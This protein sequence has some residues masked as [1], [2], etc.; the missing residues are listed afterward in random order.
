[1]ALYIWNYSSSAYE[2][3][4]NTGDNSS[5]STLTESITSNIID[6][7]GGDSNNTITLFAVTNDKANGNSGRPGRSNEGY[8]DIATDY[9]SVVITTP[10]IPIAD[11]RFDEC[12][13]TGTGTKIIDQSDNN[14]DARVTGISAS[15][16]GQINNAL[17]LSANGTSDWATLPN[18][19]ING[20]DDFTL[21]VWV[22]TSTR[23]KQ[24]EIV[25]ALGGST[26]DDQLKLALNYRKWNGKLDRST[27]DDQL[28]LALNYDN[29]VYLTVDD[30]STYL[31]AGRRL[32]DGEWHHLLVTRD[33]NDVCLFVDGDKKDCND[34][35][36]GS[37]TLSVTTPNAVIIGQ[38]HDR[39][40]GRE[41]DSFG[42][43][44]TREQNFVG[45]LDEFKIFNKK[46]AENQVTALYAH[47][48]AAKNYD[49]TTRPSIACTVSQIDHYEIIHDG[50]GLTCEDE[51]VTI[52]ACTES[53]CAEVSSEEVSV[54]LLGNATAL[55]SS[56]T[57]T[58]SSSV[59]FS[60]STAETLT[61]SLDNETSTADNSVVCNN[62]SS[63]SC[64]IVFADAGFR[65]L[66][67]DSNAST[68]DNQTAGTV[69]SEAVKLQAV[70]NENGVCSGLFSDS[71]SVALAQENVTPAG[72]DGL[73]FKIDGS[74]VAKYPDSS[75]ISL[76]FDSDS[77]ATLTNP[78]YNDAGQIRLRADYNIG[79]I[80]LTG[81]SN[82]FWVS[83][84]Y[85]SVSAQSNGSDIDGAASSAGTIHK[86]GADFTLA[87][88]A[89]NSQG[90]ITT[91]Y[92]PGNMQFQLTRSAP[93][94]T[95]TVNGIL[96]YADSS[97]LSSALSGSAS[98]S[99]VTLSSFDNGVSSYSTAQ[100]SEVGLLN[101][102]VQDSNYGDENIVVSADAINIG[103][104]TPAYF[105]IT[106]TTDGSL[107]GTPFVYSGQMANSSST[108]GKIS[109]TTQP[110]FTITAKSATGSSTLNYTGDFMKLQATG[111]VRVTPSRDATQLGADGS[112][113]VDLTANLNSAVLGGSNG[114]FIYQFNSIDNYV[115]THNANALVAPFT[116]DIDLQI[117]SITDSD[118]ITAN[119]TDSDTDNGILTLNPAGVEIRFGR[120]VMENSYG[121]ETSSLRVPMQLQYWDGSSFATNSSD[122]FTAFSSSSSA[123]V[124]DISLA[125]ATTTAS[126]SATFADG[127][128][129]ILT[130]S[131][132]GAGNRG[133]VEVEF[134]APDWL[135]YD[136]DN[137][138]SYDDNPSAEA[139]FGLY[140]GNDRIIYRR[141][142]FE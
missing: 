104:F 135:K 129:N 18:N 140:R 60:H 92:S 78:V 20:L 89:Y 96:S 23:K 122:S 139:T 74:A 43:R 27:Y 91:N 95:G 76:L 65:F 47:E 94:D 59:S 142:I 109:Y 34:N 31:N 97:T 12:T 54:D 10:D 113:K 134:D 80:T 24:Q 116:A 81:S 33:G 8:N 110:E 123:T 90:D 55:T 15:V 112:N 40:G 115:Y 16:S 71:V 36:V 69:F 22:N 131:S 86:A 35:P 87:V 124:A 119:D 128:T 56:L 83:P 37:A 70:E 57:F 6:Y 42:G 44:F 46:L 66:Y 127:E 21:S 93:L 11:Y 32:T 75:S 103:R 19:T 107:S 106:S 45:W 28:E 53:D 126:G 64:D 41:Q 52:K 51:S 38:E 7:I 77:I 48:S 25:H 137:D 108:D 58:G 130:L 141:E 79:G 133:S 39:F 88:S 5:R 73:S 29:R 114:E 125:P 105:E 2:E 118:A 121:P 102:D 1:M 50:A 136:W 84:S 63:D 67:G 120:W 17:D 117:S 82:L 9:I 98:F 132:P 62:G 101:L 68:I 49:G 138:G 61:L 26:D 4:A 14:Y 72:S 85:L 30:K 3:I 111:V 13:Y 100:Y 99:D